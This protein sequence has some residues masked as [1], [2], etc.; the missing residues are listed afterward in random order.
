MMKNL[1]EKKLPGR[2]GRLGLQLILKE[3]Q[4]CYLRRNQRRTKT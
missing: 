2:Y 4:N 3:L 1:Y